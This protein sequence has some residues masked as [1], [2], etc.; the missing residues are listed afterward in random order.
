EAHLVPFEMVLAATKPAAVMPSYN[1]IDGIPSHANKWLLQDVLRK[2]FG[3][4]GLITSDYSGVQDLKAFHHVATTEADAALRAFNAGVDMDLPDGV[5]Y[6]KLGDLVKSGKILTAALD[7][8]VRRVLCLKF[9]LGL[10]ENPFADAAKASSLV[11]LDTTR[12]LALEAARKSIVLL[13]N[14]NA[15]LPLTKG[16]QKTI[17]V[18]G[19]HSDDTRLGSYS[20]EPTHRVSVLD[21]IR[22]AVGDSGK[23]IYSKGCSL[24]TNETASPMNAWLEV[25]LQVF[26]TPA[27]DQAAIADAVEVARNADLVVLVLGE[28]ELICR[29]SWAPHHIGDRSSLDLIGAQNQLADAIFALGK[30]VVVYLMNGR[31]LAIPKIIERANA[32]LEGWY[33]GQETGNAAADIL[34]GQVNPSAKLTITVPRSVGQIPI[35]Y[36]HKPSSHSFSYL[37][38]V[39]S[40]LFPFGFGLSYTKFDCGPVKLSAAAIKRDGHAQARVIV[41]NSGSTAGDEIVQLYITDRVASVTRPVKSLKGFRRIHLAPGASQQVE[42]QITPEMLSLYDETMNRVVEPGEFEIIIGNSSAADNL[43]VLNVTE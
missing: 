40:P 8:S 19:P 33:A 30:P 27:E 25:D 32:V 23:V 24:T 4:E 3:Y 20:G 16:A 18:I 7:A 21:G 13:K 38:E 26:P 29:E 17:A 31:P 42:F 14:D 5:C 28:N 36:N 10:F 2:Q 12:A 43:A 22:R 39:S 37:D 35:Y 41:T 34:F 1:E 6:A 15:L 9:R 11:K